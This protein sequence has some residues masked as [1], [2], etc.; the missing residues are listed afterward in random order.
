MVVFQTGFQPESRL[1]SQLPAFWHDAV[2][3]RFGS[4]RPRVL[5]LG[6]GDSTDAVR[7]MEAVNA[8]T[9]VGS[10]QSAGEWKTH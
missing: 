10:C 9:P 2:G 7:Y 3:V 1:L 5:H 8:T 4:L 6:N